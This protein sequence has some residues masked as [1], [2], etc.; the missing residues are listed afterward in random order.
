MALEIS[1]RF[2]PYSFYLI[3]AKLYDAIGSVGGIQAITFLG[4]LIE[5]SFTK[6]MWHLGILT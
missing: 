3:S 5:P 4:N 6:Q 1:N 2:S